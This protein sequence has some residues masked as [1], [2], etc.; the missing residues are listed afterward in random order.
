MSLGDSG[1]SGAQ[2]G[3]PERFAPLEMQGRLIEAE[4]LARYRWAA[5]IMSGGRILDAGC[6]LA[7]GTKMLSQSGG[8]EVIGVD[9]ASAV[10][11]S[12]RADMP[13]NVRLEVGDV[14]DLPYQDD[15]FDVVVCFE[16]IEH[17]DEPGVALDELTRVLAPDGLLLVSSPNRNVTPPINPHHHHEF[18][19]Q[20]LAEE[21]DKRL[22][23]VRLMR[24]QNYLASGILTD[25]AYA[26]RDR[27]PV[28]AL[29][30]YKLLAGSADC[31][32][33]TLALASDGPLPEPPMVTTLTGTVDLADI[34]DFFEKQEA[35]LRMH[36]RRIYELEQQLVDYQEVKERLI[37]AE[38][39]LDRVEFE[40]RLEEQLEAEIARVRAPLEATQ[41]ILD[42]VV[43]SPSWRLT[44]PLR[45][46][47][48]LLDNR[49]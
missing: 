7:Y 34:F 8:D 48:R 18:L 46:A 31:E 38:Q 11:D 40:D 28:E 47:K 41:R 12:V 33:F 26:E 43:S 20:E 4:H 5:A 2:Q 17:L 44:A 21:M 24:Q 36:G 15:S 9:L 10:L 49:S 3:V 45:A 16:V 39:G 13:A 22:R 14:R 30:V 35:Q 27:G 1:P 23:N 6:G 42:D 32:T 37:E 25:E 29:Q 19:P